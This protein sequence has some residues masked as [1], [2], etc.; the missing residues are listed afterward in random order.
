MEAIKKT[1]V[2]KAYIYLMSDVD[3]AE[4]IDIPTGVNI[5]FET[6]D[7]TIDDN[8]NYNVNQANGYYYQN[9]PNP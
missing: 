9:A 4:T 1:K 3:I 8:A 5:T 7:F 6:T 2:K